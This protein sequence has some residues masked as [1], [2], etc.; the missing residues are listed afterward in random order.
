MSSVMIVSDAHHND[1]RG[2]DTQHNDT[3]HDDAQDNDTGLSLYTWRNDSQYNATTHN[4][5]NWYTQLNEIQH[6]HN[7][8]YNAEW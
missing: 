6:K 4:D 1:A 8:S 5:L 2:N 7:V 3:Q